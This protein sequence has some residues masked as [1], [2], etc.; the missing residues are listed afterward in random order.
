MGIDWDMLKLFSIP[1][2]SVL[3]IMDEMDEMDDW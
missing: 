3:I 2:A 1:S